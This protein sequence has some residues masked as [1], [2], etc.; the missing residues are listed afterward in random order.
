MSYEKN[1]IVSLFSILNIQQSYSEM[2]EIKTNPSSYG[3]KQINHRERQNK[4]YL[5][6]DPILVLSLI[7]VQLK[8]G[9]R[10]KLLPNR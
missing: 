8:E 9:I 10:A 4:F 1:Q 7:L 2:A 3:K 5:D 6:I